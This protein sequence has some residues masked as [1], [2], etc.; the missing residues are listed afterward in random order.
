MDLDLQTS[1]SQDLLSQWWQRC[2]SLAMELEPECRHIW[3]ERISEVVRYYRLSVHSSEAA[4]K[5]LFS[6]LC[7]VSLAKS[8]ADLMNFMVSG[9]IPLTLMQQLHRLESSLESS[10]E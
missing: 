4:E 5:K 7:Q 1:V 10:L 3:L 6:T 9:H 2:G 8:R